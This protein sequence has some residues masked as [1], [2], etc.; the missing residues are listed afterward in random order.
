MSRSF[1][2]WKEDRQL[3]D[4]D[5]L[6]SDCDSEISNEILREYIPDFPRGFSILID[7][8][9]CKR[10][11]FNPNTVVYGRLVWRGYYS[12]SFCGG[13]DSPE[14]DIRCPE[15]FDDVG[16]LRDFL[17]YSGRE[18]TVF[19]DRLT[20]DAMDDVS[21][22]ECALALTYYTHWLSSWT[23]RDRPIVTV[24]GDVD[25]QRETMRETLW[26]DYPIDPELKGE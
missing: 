25:F 24:C 6:W 17:F 13:R 15:K 9:E 26:E 12:D 7:P 8:I 3:L 10:S 20:K 16:W 23:D 22:A 21:P 5:A 18:A 14:F 4:L 2:E 1:E 11:A 19:C